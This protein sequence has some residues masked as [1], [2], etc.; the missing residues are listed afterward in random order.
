MIPACRH[1]KLQIIRVQVKRNPKKRPGKLCGPPP[2][3]GIASVREPSR[4]VEQGKESHHL[5]IG[6]SRIGQAETVLT[7]TGPVPW[8]VDT[9]P[10]ERKL[11]P[12]DVE[13]LLFTHH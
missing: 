3:L 8:A 7:D 5:A 11:N 12:D 4:V 1:Q 13:Q 6:T 2:M 10:V 9:I